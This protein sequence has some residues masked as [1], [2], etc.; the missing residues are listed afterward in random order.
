MDYESHATGLDR[1]E[2]GALLVAAGLGTAAEHA[3]ISVLVL[4]GLR[5]SEA[6]GADIDRLGLQRGH[7]TLTIVRKGGK[8]VTVP[9]AP[10][11]AR[12]IDLAIGER[13]EGPIFL[14]AGVP[15]RDVQEAASHADPLTTTGYDR[16]GNNLDRHATHIV[17]AFVVGPPLTSWYQSS[18]A[19]RA[20]CPNAGTVDLRGLKSA[21]G[22]VLSLGVRRMGAFH[23]GSG[24][25]FGPPLP[26]HSTS[27]VRIGGRY[28]LA[29]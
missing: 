12:A 27:C 8:I 10:R 5:V 3:L 15:L 23:G 25:E 24:L 16:A 2:L 9:L 4:N 11:T 6:T 22:L 29:K 7:R 1:N 20:W 26:C 18:G 21:V 28:F 19:P 17:A 14:G 13:V